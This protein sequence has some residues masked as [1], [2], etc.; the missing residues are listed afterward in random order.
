MQILAALVAK[1]RVAFYK[2]LPRAALKKGVAGYFGVSQGR[3][4]EEPNRNTK[5]A[6]PKYTC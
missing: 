4:G 6:F 2:P 5:V 1:E 3:G